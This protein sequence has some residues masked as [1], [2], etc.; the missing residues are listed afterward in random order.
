MPTDDTI[1]SLSRLSG[2]LSHD[3]ETLQ[4]T[5][6]A[7]SRLGDIGAPLEQAG[8]ALANMPD[9]DEQT[10][11]GCLA[12][13]THGTGTGIGCMSTFI[14]GLQLVDARGEL[15]DCDRQRN[16]QLFDAA[17]VSLGSLGIITQVRLQNM[18]PYRLRRET[19]WRE[20]DEMLA[21]AESEADKHRNFEFYYVP[22]SG[23][24]FTD[25][26]DITTEAVSSTG[27]T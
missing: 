22:F 1:V 19:V 7:G 23:M 6:W 15:V 24:G 11:A 3:P 4:A 17:R 2:V 13:A 10:L 20:F 21:I 16:A 27:K 18:A 8:Q 25:T 9:I 26:H 5:L 14:E 12:T